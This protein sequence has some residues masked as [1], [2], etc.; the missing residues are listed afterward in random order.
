MK[1]AIVGDYDLDVLPHMWDDVPAIRERI[2]EDQNLIMA[3]DEATG[4]VACKYVDATVQ[5]LNRPCIETC[6]GFDEGS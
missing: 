2:R 4:G 1:G 6:I 3:F 5:N